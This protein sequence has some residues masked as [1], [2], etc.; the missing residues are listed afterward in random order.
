M[1]FHVESGVNP[2][3][4]FQALEPK[5]E[6]STRGEHVDAHGRLVQDVLDGVGLVL[7]RLIEMNDFHVVLYGAVQRSSAWQVPLLQ[8]SLWHSA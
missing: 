5:V 2:G 7:L 6:R 8:L 3:L 4:F 1:I